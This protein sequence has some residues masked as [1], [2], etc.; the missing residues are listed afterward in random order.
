VLYWPRRVFSLRKAIL[1]SAGMFVTALVLYPGCFSGDAQFS[2]NEA[3][4][5]ADLKFRDWHPPL[6]AFIWHVLNMLP[7]QPVPRYANLFLA[8]VCLFWAGVALAAEPWERSSIRWLIFCV[9]V[10]MFPPVFAILSQTIKDSLLCSAL[11]A[12]YGGLAVAEQRRSWAAY[13]FGLVCLFLALGFRHNAIFAVV[14]LGLWAGF[15]L[16]EQIVP[17]ALRLRLLGAAR[18]GLVG[19]AMTAGLGVGALALTEGLT[20]NPSYTIQAIY[21]FDLLG[22]SVK[23]GKVYLPA[24]FDDY[25]KPQWWPVKGSEIAASPLTLDNLTQ[26]YSPITNLGIYWYGPGKGLRI[27]DDPAE[28]EAL[29]LAWLDAIR[30]NFLVYLRVRLD[31]FLTLLGIHANPLGPYYCV[32]E[33]GQPAADIF[34][35]PLPQFYLRLKDSIIFKGWFYLFSLLLFLLVL[36]KYGGVLPRRLSFLALSG[37]SYGVSYFVIAPSADFRYLYWLMV[38]F[39]LIATSLGFSAFDRASSIWTE[40]HAGSNKLITTGHGEALCAREP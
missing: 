25:S 7:L 17:R 32:W 30:D 37:I 36:M 24:L 2:W 26:L 16:C 10:G 27:T 40:W 23:T 18:R 35:R 29:K 39:I 34:Y 21:T 4:S 33:Q 9:C 8:M 19:L 13:G 28:V 1:V 22:I 11:I 3:V 31:V 15:I 5:S 14:P 20:N 38:V 12:A 6:I